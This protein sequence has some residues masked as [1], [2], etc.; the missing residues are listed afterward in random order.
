MPLTTRR[1]FI[2]FS[3]FSIIFKILKYK[4]SYLNIEDIHNLSHSIII[5]PMNIIYLFISACYY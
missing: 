2:C 5:T 4:K 1:I 3:I